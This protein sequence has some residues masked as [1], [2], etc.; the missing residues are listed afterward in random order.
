MHTGAK[1]AISAN[2]VHARAFAVG[3]NIVFGNREYR[4]SSRTGQK[5]IAHELTHILQQRNHF[6][7]S[8]KILLGKSDTNLER[9][10]EQNATTIAQGKEG[11]T[12][13]T[14]L[15]GSI[16][17]Q[18][19]ELV[20]REP[21][22]EILQ[23]IPPEP[24][25][26]SVNPD[27]ANLPWGRYVDSYTQV[28]YD[29]D[30]RSEG[31]NLSTWMRLIYGDGT[32]IDL[33]INNIIDET[34]NPTF[35]RDAL[36]NGYIGEGSRI[37]PD[38]MNGSTTPRLARAKQS[39]LEIMDEYNL[40]FIMST[41]PAVTF[42]IS[43]PLGVAGGVRPT[44]RPAPSRIRPSGQTPN[45]ARNTPPASQGSSP[46]GPRSVGA[47]QRV[48]QSGG[49]TIRASTA[50]ELNELAGKNLSRREWGRILEALKREHGLPNNHHGSITPSGNYIDEF[51]NVIDNLLDYIP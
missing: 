4:P 40:Q 43:M 38:G 29:L 25:Y 19:E 14:P 3:N 50:R 35:L 8:N 24:E 23:C 47:A 36:A 22:E 30:Y 27:I 9:E 11:K 10:A 39:V 26:P 46:F 33:N 51:G 44:V 5:L 18:R 1:A 34:L 41:L 17:L 2:A 16:A 45:P 48:L 7:P 49:R 13:I 32:E 20:C 6:Q 37:F 31:G 15:N 42:I 28:I 21:E 12:L